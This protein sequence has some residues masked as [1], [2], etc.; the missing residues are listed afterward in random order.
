MLF[1]TRMNPN[2]PLT[3]AA[4]DPA[5]SGSRLDALEIKLCDCDDSIE[6]LN[7]ALYRQ[8][9][10]IARLMAQ[11]AQLLLQ[12]PEGGQG[13]AGGGRDELPPHY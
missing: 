7:L 4:D 5:A 8:Q 2:P 11:V 1:N 12:M 10:Q 9:Q 3:E 13:A 6:Q